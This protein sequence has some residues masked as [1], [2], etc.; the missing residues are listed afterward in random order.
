MK[1]VLLNFHPNWSGQI[2][3][4]SAEVTLNGGL[5]RE[6]PQNPFFSVPEGARKRHKK[7]GAHRSDTLTNL[8]QIGQ[9]KT[10]QLIP[11]ELCMVY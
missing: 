11:K 4:T 8:F 7:H 9:E 6:L 1:D 5:V 2:M 3:T 10:H